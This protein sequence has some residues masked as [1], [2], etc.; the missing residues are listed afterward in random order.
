MTDI[1]GINPL[2][3]LSRHIEGLVARAAPSI[4]AIEGKERETTSGIV[5][6]PGWIVASDEAIDG[7]DG[8][9]ARLPDGRT[10]GA[11]L[12]GRDPSTDIALLKVDATDLPAIVLSTESVPATGS[13]A[14]AV[15]RRAEGSVVHLR[16]VSLVGPQWQSMRGGRID[17]LIRLDG[18]ADAASEGSAVLDAEGRVLGMLAAGPRRGALVIPSA[19]IQRVADTLATHGRV[20]RGYIG[21][22]LQPVRIEEALR[23]SLGLPETEGVMVVS[24][25]GTGPG[26]AAG[27]LQG[28]IITG[29]KGAPVTSLRQIMRTLG[30]ESIG[31]T[32]DLVIVRAGTKT[33][34]TV[35]IAARPA[36]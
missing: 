16:N 2:A 19:T 1:T 5:W 25:D 30:P 20:A 26:K 23:T 6:K 15:G 35:T 24:V 32:A 36:A 3:V 9:T 12:A 18:R 17:H 29:W 10:L 22:G 4:V 34:A 13:L 28:D 11:T 31:S 21:L 33:S 14:I 7:D 8:L 27:V